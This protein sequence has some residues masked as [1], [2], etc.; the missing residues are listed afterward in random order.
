MIRPC[1]GQVSEDHNNGYS[2]CIAWV[3][4]EKT[5]F[6]RKQELCK[7]NARAPSFVKLLSFRPDRSSWQISYR[8]DARSKQTPL[9]LK[10]HVLLPL[11]N[12]FTIYYKAEPI[13]KQFVWNEIEKNFSSFYLLPQNTFVVMN[14]NERTDVFHLKTHVCQLYLLLHPSLFFDFFFRLLCNNNHCVDLMCIC[15]HIKKQYVYE[16]RP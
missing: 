1:N 4:I 2:M 7:W 9:P 16:S 15:G 6:E 10:T 11:I 8:L 5:G 13:D 14:A 3:F 12:G